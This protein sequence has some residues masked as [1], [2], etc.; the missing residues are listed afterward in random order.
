[1]AFDINKSLGIFPEALSLHEQRAE[2]L[3]NN[4]ANQDTPGFKAK[5]ID[6]RKAL[7]AVQSDNIMVNASDI[8]ATHKQ[9]IQ[10]DQ[11]YFMNFMQY[12]N[13]TQPNMDG[14]TVDG[15]IEQAEFTQNSMRYMAN[16]QFLNNRLK[17]LMS[18]IKGN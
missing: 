18:A 14:N 11:N 17:S 2:L 3:A 16:L 10:H 1:M 9:H 15:Q 5:D 4:L 7:Q 12:R 6:F 8:S 13:L